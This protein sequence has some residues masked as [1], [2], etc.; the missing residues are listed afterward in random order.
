M[1]VAI[2]VMVKF[3]FPAPGKRPPDGRAELREESAHPL[4]AHLIS[5]KRGDVP[6]GQSKGDES[7]IAEV[8][9]TGLL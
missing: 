6:D 8:W 3:Q 2:I 9:E 1:R 4:L 7:P 5:L